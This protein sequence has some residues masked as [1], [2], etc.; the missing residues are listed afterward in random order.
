MDK[1]SE[2]DAKTYADSDAEKKVTRIAS[3]SSNCLVKNEMTCSALYSHGSL[4]T[5]HQPSLCSFCVIGRF[6]LLERQM[7]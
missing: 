5:Y 4:S 7:E 3:Y 2:A 1:E 6:L